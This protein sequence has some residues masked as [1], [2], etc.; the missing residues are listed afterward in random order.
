MKRN[1]SNEENSSDLLSDASPNLNINENENLL[2]EDTLDQFRNEEL[3]VLDEKNIPIDEVTRSN[4]KHT[5]QEVTEQGPP[6]PENHWFF[7]LFLPMKFSFE[8][9]T[10]PIIKGIFKPH[11]ERQL[12]RLPKKLTAQFV[13]SR[14]KNL[15]KIHKNWK[16]PLFWCLIRLVWG[17][18][19]IAGIFNISLR[20]LDLIVP[21]L[22]VEMLKA[23]K[24]NSENSFWI[25]ISYAIIIGIM[26][27]FWGTLMQLSNHHS[28]RSGM[29]A[30]SAIISLLFDKS[31]NMQRKKDEVIT[32][33]TVDVMKIETAF[34]FFHFLWTSIY[35]VI[36]AI[37]LLYTL[38]G[39][40]SIG[41]ILVVSSI[42]PIQILV[43]R[44]TSIFQ[45]KGL[46]WTD[47]R[48]KLINEIVSG[49]Q[50]LKFYAWENEYKRRV[51]EIREKEVNQARKTTA[52]KAFNVAFMSIIPVLVSCATFALYA[53]F[54]GS[55]ELFIVFPAI[56]YFELMRMP[57][58]HFPGLINNLINANVSLGRIEKFMSELEIDGRENLINSNEDVEDSSN[59]IEF[60]DATFQWP[61]FNEFHSK[62]KTKSYF[63][64][65]KSKEHSKLDDEVELPEIDKENKFE[66]TKIKDINL[67]IKRGDLVLVVGEVGSG[68]T[69]LLSS[70]LG[71]M[72]LLGG[73]LKSTGSISYVPQTPFLRNST[74]R[75]NI[76]FGFKMNDDLYNE[77]IYYSGLTT[78]L[79]QLNGDLTEIG[80]LG[81]NLSGGQK[82][83][84]CLARALYYDGEIYL[85][86]DC[87]SALDATVGKFIFEET[88]CGFLSGKTR[89]LVTH[90]LHYCSQ[91]DYIVVMEKGKIVEQG[92]YEELMSIQGGKLQDLIQTYVL[93]NE[94]QDE[95]T[96]KEKSSKNHVPRSK[97]IDDIKIENGKKLQNNKHSNDIGSKIIQ[98][99]DKASGRIKF[100]VIK[101]YA[102][103]MGGWHIPIFI[104]IFFIIAQFFIFGPDLWITLWSGEVIEPLRGKLYINLIIYSIIGIVSGMLVIFRDLFF[105]LI[106]LQGSKTLH[107]KAFSR[108]IRAPMSWFESQ[109]MAR[110]VSRFSA[111]VDTTDS[112]L[113]A[114]LHVAVTF[115]FQAIAICLV[116][117]FSTSGIFIIPLII[118]TA[119][120]WIISELYSKSNREFKRLDSIT[121]SPM[122]SYFSETINGLSSVRSYN[123]QEFC[124]KEQL[125]RITVNMQAY[126]MMQSCTRWLGIRLDT[127]GSLLILFISICSFLIRKTSLI[128]PTFLAL[129]ITYGLQFNRVMSWFIRNAAIAEVN[130]NSV[131]RL[132][133]YA[134]DEIPVEAPWRIK[135]DIPK[136]WPN[137]GEIK[138]NNIHFRYRPDLE[139]TLKDLNIKIESEQKV[140]I[141][142]RTGSGKSST[143]LSLFRERELRLGNILIDGVDISKIGL[144]DLREQLT[145]I[146]QNPVCFLGTVRSN[147]DPFG[148]H[149]DI[150]LWNALESTQMKELIEKL[151]GL[152]ARI[153]EGGGNLSIGERALLVLTRALL[154]KRK[155]LI[156]DEASASMDLA[157][158]SK[159]QETIRKE[160]SDCTTITIAHRIDTIIDSNIIF[161]LDAGKV[162]ESGSP[163]ELLLNTESLFYKMVFDTGESS[164]KKLFQKV[165]G[166]ENNIEHLEHNLNE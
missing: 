60:V 80:S 117:S 98:K 39:W 56:S 83:R 63:P 124:M 94:T 88:I 61:V 35:Q 49:I 19:L 122:L 57:L 160:F 115:F 165:F 97:S 24:G 106:L 73:S 131:E 13:Y 95:T 33:I 152:D 153:E 96:N 64:F 17:E 107:D 16:R 155:I 41:A 148:K 2:G 53:L 69:S 22:M 50:L 52:T 135:T 55:L 108:I 1:H 105:F 25:G 134:S 59:S 93:T 128:D 123:S 36:S 31:L 4:Y 102:K 47:S 136:G 92:N 145:I 103:A 46:K 112:E 86:D 38:V 126:Y 159:I 8:W 91:A 12:P 149:S 77:S 51:S 163:K 71:E 7:K 143:I 68:K 147:L 23:L 137:K 44:V 62:V 114:S 5:F 48:V 28:V 144:H 140:A 100:K 34:Q 146:P 90:Q 125:R 111:D 154:R 121:R 15:W 43:G 127:I 37:I 3:D 101:S 30:R 130:M 139:D 79:E 42:I 142:G 164:R 113:I 29:R 162:I 84:I 119:L 76:L 81:V 156:S 65:K 75:Q 141:V 14:I 158:D 45:R 82:A 67:K 32:L 132:S 87:L 6:P 109:P 129:G 40:A 74:I 104:L 21:L 72:Q 138:F 11:D 151:G 120:F 150:K 54:G 26:K 166:D 161:V 66:S 99:E 27:I 110:I 58:S 85:M 10:I 70:I 118:I 78:D 157:L 20:T 116:I 133:H 89:I 18:F 9:M